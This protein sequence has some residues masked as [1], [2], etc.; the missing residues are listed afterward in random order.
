MFVAKSVLVEGTLLD[1]DGASG[2]LVGSKG[3]RECQSEHC[4]N[5]RLDTSD[6]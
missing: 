4:L 2:G 5:P 3:R 6:E 1:I